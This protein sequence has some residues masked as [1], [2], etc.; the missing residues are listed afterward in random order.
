MI[1][2]FKIAGVLNPE[3]RRRKRSR[4][5]L[6]PARHLLYSVFC[7]LCSVFLSLCFYG[8][9]EP[10]EEAALW[11]Q[12]KIDELA[13]QG[14]N[15]APGTR[16]IKTIN[17]DVHVFEVP[18]ENVDKL[19]K[20]RKRFYIRPL[21]LVDY[22]AF[23][24]NSFVVRF[25]K[26]EMWNELREMLVAADG[27]RAGKVSLLLADEQAQTIAV[28][29]SERS[30]TISFAGKGGSRQAANVGTGSLGL[31]IK[32]AK[33]PGS[34]GVCDVVAYPV[35]S[36]PAQSP[37]PEL[38]TRVKQR[39]FAFTAAAFALDMTPGDFV[40]LGPRQLV[41]DL[42]EL[43]GLFFSNPKGS[44]FLNEASRR[45]PELKPSVRVFLLVCTR[46]DD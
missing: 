12:V 32:A 36:P 10:K 26:A 37:I 2:V 20:I 29:A 15:D 41:S 5:P 40:Y 30:G 17:L 33:I 23:N 3:F 21:R 28:A 13:P 45:P 38:Q 9:N 42:T 6:R 19:D 16:I 35:F 4:T 7:V 43:G 24:A 31:R 27:Q 39:E 44:L 46:I 22:Q 18:A 11:D 1:R 8:C 34:R 14:G 25:G